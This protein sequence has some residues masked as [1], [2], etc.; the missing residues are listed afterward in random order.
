MLKQSEIF[1]KMSYD[2]Y[3]GLTALLVKKPKV[4]MAFS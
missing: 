4:K 2:G 1:N 3:D